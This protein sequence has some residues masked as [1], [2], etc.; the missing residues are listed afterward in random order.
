[1]KVSL[2]R[3]VQSEP[4]SPVAF[5]LVNW[6]TCVRWSVTDDFLFCLWCQYLKGLNM[7]HK[8][9]KKILKVH[10]SS[11]T[12]QWPVPFSPCSVLY[13]EVAYYI[14][15]VESI[16]DIILLCVSINFFPHPASSLILF[17][18]PDA[19]CVVSQRCCIRVSDTWPNIRILNIYS[20]IR[21]LLFIREY[22]SI[23]IYYSVHDHE[24]VEYRI[25]DWS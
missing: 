19:V 18:C 2:A 16:L 9:T 5:Q 4:V 8:I 21:Y 7:L 24:W 20:N 14:Q 13:R 23:L 1:M 17:N 15:P 11:L 12:G 10:T 6:L 22:S 25:Y 3:A